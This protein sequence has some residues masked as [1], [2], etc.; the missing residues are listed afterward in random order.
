MPLPSLSLRRRLAS[1]SFLF[2]ALYSLLTSS[3]GAQATTGAIEGR[4]FNPATGSY[5]ERVRLTVAG[6]TL[7]T[8]TDADGNYR[9][10]GV[11]AGTAQ[12]LAFRTGLS[13]STTTVTIAA[14]GI[15]QHTIN[16]A[17]ADAVTSG[18]SGAAAPGL[19]V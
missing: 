18:K 16:L 12:V 7:E 5:V 11:P 17:A 6:T 10:A 19:R 9:L 2:L 1:A 13:P 15:A 14:G 8:F 3:L 4:V